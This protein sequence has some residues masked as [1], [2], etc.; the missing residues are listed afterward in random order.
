[1]TYEEFKGA[2]DVVNRL[3]MMMG[4]VSRERFD[5]VAQLK[6][7]ITDDRLLDAMYGMVSSLP[8]LIWY[9]AHEGEEGVRQPKVLKYLPK[10]LEIVEAAYA[11]VKRGWRTNDVPVIECDRYRQA[12]RRRY[13][14]LEKAERRQVDI[15]LGSR[16]AI[17]L[18]AE[19]MDRDDVELIGVARHL[20]Y[21]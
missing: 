9:V 4:Y 18:L 3:R 12:D 13:F 2:A 11:V 6:F 20:G 16:S 14:Y 7:D 8:R 10:A 17:I 5:M 15:S 19:L 21:L 1:M